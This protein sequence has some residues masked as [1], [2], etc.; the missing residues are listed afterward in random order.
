MQISAEPVSNWGP[1]GWKAELLQIRQPCPPFST[2][3]IYRKSVVKRG[4][5]AGRVLQLEERLEL[6]A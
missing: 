4:H 3:V 5:E 1:C 2:V 6:I